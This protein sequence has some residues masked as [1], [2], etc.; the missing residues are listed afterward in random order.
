MKMLNLKQAIKILHRWFGLVFAIPL[1]ISGITG[2][3]IIVLF[4]FSDISKN[5]SNANNYEPSIQ[6]IKMALKL[7][8]D[9]V[10]LLRFPAKEDGKI[11]I[12]ITKKPT[13]LLDVTTM[14]ITNAPQNSFT[15]IMVK[16][17]S[18][19]LLSSIGSYIVGFMGVVL[20]FYL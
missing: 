14:E 2:S 20:L 8:G 19:L 17:H 18:E 3:V 5:L 7:A 15:R 16:L 6:D 9:G 13:L 10:F 1:I 12:R 4:S 11:N